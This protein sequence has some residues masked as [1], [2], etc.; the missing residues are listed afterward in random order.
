MTWPVPVY[1]KSQIRKAGKAIL[2][3]DNETDVY[4]NA[5]EKIENWRSSHGYPINTF[6]ATLR[7][8]LKIIDPTALVSQRL[9]RMESILNK[10]YR[11]PS[12]SLDK[13]Q[14]FGGLRAVVD[15]ITRLRILES[16]YL[17]SRFKHEL[18]RCHDYVSEPKES[19]YRSIHLVYKY[20]NPLATEYNGLLIELQLRTSLQHAW[21]TAVETMGTFLEQALKSSEGEDEWLDYFSLCSAAFSHLESSPVHENYYDIEPVEIY[22]KLILLTE[23]YQVIDKLKGFT[24]ATSNITASRKRGAY[25]LV[26]LNFK[27]RLLSIFTY[28]KSEL[29]IATE[30]YAE[31][32]KEISGGANKHAVLVSAGN[33]DNLRRAYPSYFLDTKEF[34][35][36]LNKVK[37]ECE[38]SKA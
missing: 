9:K 32:E 28:S 25:H 22:K 8:K 7:H 23:K 13:M 5:F 26:V 24:V 36:Y 19:G 20:D 15:N 18:I 27:E 11:F 37:R 12:M 30:V 21:A 29:E 6:Q 14:D 35:G 38:K 16:N 1:S 34:I 3:Q 33:I 31:I 17:N 2:N 4:I 10:L